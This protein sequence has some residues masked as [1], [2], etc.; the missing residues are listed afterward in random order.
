[1]GRIIRYKNNMSSVAVDEDLQGKHKDYSL[2]YRCSRLDLS[3][4]EKN[5]RFFEIYN[6]VNKA[7]SMVTAV[8]ECAC[9]IERKEEKNESK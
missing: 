9:F 3:D 6:S 8:W 1:M 5:C 2:C 4:P 7:L